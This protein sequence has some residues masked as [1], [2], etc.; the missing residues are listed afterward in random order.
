MNLHLYNVHRRIYFIY[1]YQ[2]EINYT[3][4]YMSVLHTARSF[5]HIQLPIIVAF[6]VYSFEAGEELST[7]SAIFVA[8]LAVPQEN[9]TP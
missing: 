3:S 2:R 1:I 4:L 9:V 5:V 6:H 8:A 7:F